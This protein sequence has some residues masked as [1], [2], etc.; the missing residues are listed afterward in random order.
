MREASRLEAIATRVEAIT[1]R[2]KLLVAKGIK[3]CETCPDSQDQAKSIHEP[4]Y[5]QE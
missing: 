4:G 5:L 1:S 2:K 3:A